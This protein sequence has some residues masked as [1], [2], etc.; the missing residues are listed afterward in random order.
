MTESIGES[1]GGF[2]HIASG[3][4]GFQTAVDVLGF[5]YKPLEYAKFHRS[6]PHIP[7]YGSETASTVSSRGE[8]FFPVS[9]DKREG[10]VN[11]Q[12]S[13]YD[14]TAPPWAWSPYVEFRWLEARQ[15]TAG[16]FVWTGLDYTDAFFYS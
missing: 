16:D 7:V 8:Y 15:F 12:V 4:N 9:D 10:A 14:L 3:Y 11:F 1:G 5:N 6:S 2:N 13:S